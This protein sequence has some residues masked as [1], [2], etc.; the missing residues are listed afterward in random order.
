MAVLRA[1][2]DLSAPPLQ[3]LAQDPLAGSAAIVG[4]GVEEIAARIKRG[5]H[6]L[7]GRGLVRPVPGRVAELPGAETHGTDAKVGIA[8]QSI[9]HAFPWVAAEAYGTSPGL[10]PVLPPV[11]PAPDV[12]R[13]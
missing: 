12:P 10:L 2:H 11:L 7:D 5:V 8:E 1:E 6:E 4:C 9:F 13:L 3:G